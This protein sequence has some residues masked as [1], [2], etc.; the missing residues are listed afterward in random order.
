MEA[1]KRKRTGVLGITATAGG[2][3]G[4]WK[5]KE[6]VMPLELGSMVNHILTGSHTV[7]KRALK[8]D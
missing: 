5:G 3:V 7:G 1:Q 6:N 2:R 4:A 8:K